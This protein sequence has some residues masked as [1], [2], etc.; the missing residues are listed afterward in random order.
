MANKLDSLDHFSKEMNISKDLKQRLR[1]AI[2]Y[3]AEKT[4]F[5]MKDQSK[6]FEPLPRSLRFELAMSMYN[7]AANS[8]PFFKGRDKVF[9]SSVVP[10]LSNIFVPTGDLIYSKDEH[11]EEMYF[12]SVGKAAYLIPE[13][14]VCYKVL[15]EGSYFGEIE[16]IQKSKRLSTIQ[17]VM[18]CSLLVMSKEVNCTQLLEK[19]TK[20]FPAIATEM[21]DIAAVK[22]KFNY[23]ARVETEAL[24]D[25]KRSGKLDRMN[26]EDLKRHLKAAVDE[27]ETALHRE[28]NSHKAV[29]EMKQLQELVQDLIQKQEADSRKL[30]LIMK[31][32]D[33]DQH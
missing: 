18:N 21:K 6:M 8:I 17:S 13:T 23:R 27:Q 26:S 12:I 10:L 20:D 3:N 11:A 32:L 2:R 1:H 15:Q 28:T 22:E 7:G 19:M 25:L 33:S 9:V 4:G 30:D 24:I 14:K 29:E 5:T 31:L 16:L